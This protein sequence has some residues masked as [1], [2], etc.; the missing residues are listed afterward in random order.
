MPRALVTGAT[1]GIGEGFTR[2]LARDGYDLVL[3]ARDQ[4]RLDALARDLVDRH[5]VRAQV[6]VA[7]LATATGRA[8]AAERLRAT[9]EP[10]DLLVNNAGFGVHQRFVG[11]DLDAETR[12]LDVLVRAVLELTHAA[13]PGM[14]ARGHGGVVNVS[15]VASFL[16]TGTYGAA[17]AWVTSF[18]RGVAGELAG[19]G[20][21]MMAVCPGFTR[22]EFHQR[23]GMHVDGVPRLAWLG[24]DHVVDTALRDLAR[25][26]SVSVPGRQYQ[27]AVAASRLLPM[28]GWPRR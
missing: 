2:R 21:R 26:R 10:V 15:S 23:A 20:V 6:L 1:A 27:L 7:D 25:G 3:V 16:P 12:L 24:V 9:E 17:K 8:G 28:N 19:T 14:V 22:T 4:H 13:L 5:R 11:G 18:S